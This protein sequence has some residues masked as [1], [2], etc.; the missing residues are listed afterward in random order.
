MASPMM[1]NLLMLITTI[2]NM[3]IITSMTH[4]HHQHPH[5]HEKHHN[6]GHHKHHEH[7]H[8]EH[9]HG[10]SMAEIR[11]IIEQS[12]LSDKVKST[13]LTIFLKIAEAEA[14]MHHSTPD[15]VHFHEIG[16]IDS[17][18]DICGVAWCLE[19]LGVNEVHCSALPHSSGLRLRTR[20][21]ANSRASHYAHFAGRADDSHRN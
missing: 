7:E 1:K 8:H 10:R 11:E 13:S 14:A 5:G 4:E 17:L 9:H 18:L 15:E 6:Y 3:S 20:T 19:Y 16:G 21:N 2:T 12:A